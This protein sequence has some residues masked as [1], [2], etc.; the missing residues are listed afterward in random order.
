MR[1][2]IQSERDME[3]FGGRLAAAATS[4]AIIY[5]QGELGAGK[6]TFA[7]GFLRAL[8]H[9]G[10]VKSPTYTLIESYALGHRTIHHLDLYRLADPGELEYLGLRDLIEPDSTCLVEW[11]ERGFG[12]LPPPDAVLSID[13]VDAH[14]REI[15]CEAMTERGRQLLAA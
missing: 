3:A 5:L 6:T 1:L 4:G 13:I 12:Q 10:R 9:A 8:G 11:P 14:A 15:T 7:R 2:R